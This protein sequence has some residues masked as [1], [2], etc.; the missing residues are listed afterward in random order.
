MKFL[1]L[2]SLL[3]LTNGNIITQSTCD[4][5]M[6]KDNVDS[7][8]QFA[9]DYQNDL[10]F[11]SYTSREINN[12]FT[13]AYLDLNTHLFHTIPEIAGGFANAVDRTDNTVYLGGNDGIYKFDKQTKIAKHF[14]S[15]TGHSVWQIFIR[16]SKIYYTT[17]KP[18]EKLFTIQDGVSK[19]VEEFADTRVRLFGIDHNDNKYIYNA[20]GLY[21]I[22]KGSKN[23]TAISSDYN[24]NA[25]DTNRNGELYFSTT[26]NGIYKIK[27]AEKIEK[28]AETTT[29]YG[30]AIAEDGSIIYGDR[31]NI[32]RFIPNG[33]DCRVVI[34]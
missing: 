4:R 33:A 17:F 29:C 25:F 27:S 23:I 26:F 6:L 21:Y 5:E 14:G 1:L 28:I 9:I 3:T 22:A 18:D 12:Y 20:T 2:L 8:Y 32:Y 16:N 30:F 7:P 24:I 13:S 10:L 19:I 11:F 31:E 15:E 34:K